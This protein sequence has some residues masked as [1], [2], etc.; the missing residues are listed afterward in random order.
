MKLRTYQKEFVDGAVAEWAKGY[1]RIAGVMATGGGKTPT[2]MTLVRMCIEAGSPVLWLAHRTELID[3]AIDKARQVA[4]DV[5]IGRLQGAVKQ[6]RAAL[7]VGSVQTAATKT[8]LPYL[9]AR[10]WGLIVVDETHHVTADT[11]MKILKELRAFEPAG[12]L[13]LGLTATLDRGDNRALGEVFESVLDPKIG[14]LD[15]IKHPD[16]PFLVPP[17]GVRVRIAELDLGRVRRSGGD[18]AA[19]ALGQAMS[20]AMAPRK[21]IEAWEKHAKGVPTLAFAP[22]VAFS[23][24]LAEAFT[25]AGYPMVHLDGTAPDAARAA[26]L[27]RFRRGEIHLTNVGLFTEGT[28]LPNIECVLMC[29]PTSSSVLYTQMV[30]RGLRLHPGKRFCWVIDF[31]GVTNRHRLATLATLDGAAGPEDVPD[32]LLMYEDDEPEETPE[33]DEPDAVVEQ[34]PYAEGDLEHELIDLFGASHSAWLRTDGGVWFLPTPHGWVYLHPQPHDRYDL[35][36]FAVNGTGGVIQADMEIGYAMAAGDEYVAQV[37]MWQLDRSA[38]WRSR[39]VNATTTRGQQWDRR[40]QQKA[41]TA[42]D[43]LLGIC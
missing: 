43:R 3:Q 39:K 11:Y 28:D 23:I 15:L 20:D 5:E 13:V 24:E 42:L 6:W 37:P 34:L 31:C 26:T 10:R 21:I 17:R 33:R 9:R 25:A 30:G 4:P 19:G 14:L 41:T 22:T 7:V 18:Y 16:G 36:Y 40:E 35:A 12:P 38:E 29:R 1:R 8:S 2:G 32:E 27:D